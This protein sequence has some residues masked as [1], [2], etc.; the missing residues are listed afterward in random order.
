MRSIINH[1]LF[2]YMLYGLCVTLLLSSYGCSSSN[3]TS[4]EEYRQGQ[5]S[6]IDRVVLVDGRVVEFDTPS[7][8]PGIYKDKA[9]IGFDKKTGQMVSIPE[10]Q[11]V[12]V[13]YSETDTTKSAL[14]GGGA[15]IGLAIVAAAVIVIVAVSDLNGIGN[16]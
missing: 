4:L 2:P 3:A 5:H 11:I 1:K 8:R 14:A 10:T 12:S 6:G 16:K 7:G 13:S 9:V 15:L